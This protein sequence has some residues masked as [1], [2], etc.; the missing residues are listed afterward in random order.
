MENATG[1]LDMSQFKVIYEGNQH[2]IRAD[3]LLDSIGS[4]TDLVSTV[5]ENLGDDRDLKIRISAPERGSFGIDLSLLSDVA[6][7]AMSED[8]V[9]YTAA[10][11]GTL[12]GLYELH[13]WLG[14]EDPDQVEDE[15][16]T[17]RVYQNDGNVKEFDADVVNIYL[18]DDDAREEL[19]S[20]YESTQRDDRVEG[21]RIEDADTGEEK[22]RADRKEFEELS[23]ADRDDEPD[24]R[25]VSDRAQVTVVRVIFDPDRKWEFLW[26]GDKLSARINDVGFW[27]RVENREEQ[28]ASSDRMEVELERVQEYD[29]NLEDWVTQ[30][31]EIT[32]VNDH[33]KAGGEQQTMFGGG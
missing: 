28:F 14:G 32:Q 17:I 29:P 22:F 12:T 11:V 30:D 26:E 5:N 19:D 10:L 23:G 8:T 31:Y 27:A 20:T 3:V 16:D 4:V 33:W 7:M 1:N 21:F 13:K 2:D 9:T 18:G 25:T 6:T 24:R 15:G